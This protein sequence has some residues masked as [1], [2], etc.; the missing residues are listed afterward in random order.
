VLKP[1]KKLVILVKNQSYFKNRVKLNVRTLVTFV[2]IY[3]VSQSSGK[4]EGNQLCGAVLYWALKK[5]L[6]CDSPWSTVV[7]VP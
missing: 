7:A 1:N 3:V 6:G 5:V 2:G 4:T